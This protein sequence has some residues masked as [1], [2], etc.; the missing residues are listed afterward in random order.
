MVPAGIKIKKEE[1]KAAAS[2]MYWAWVTTTGLI[3]LLLA[4]VI[5]AR[6]YATGN[7]WSA[8]TLI[9]AYVVLL[10][11]LIA[12]AAVARILY[13]SGYL[14]SKQTNNKEQQCSNSSLIS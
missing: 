7:R 9:L 5:G 12:S 3:T 10:T 13:D 8:V 4:C 1:V 14:G 2:D 6:L 11:V